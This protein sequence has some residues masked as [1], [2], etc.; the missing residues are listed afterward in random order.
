MEDRFSCKLRLFTFQEIKLC[1][2]GR[3]MVGDDIRE[4]VITSAVGRFSFCVA[5]VWGA[6]EGPRGE[7]SGN[8]NE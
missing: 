1:V 5:K 6:R 3:V 8:K 2:F 7:M 4:T